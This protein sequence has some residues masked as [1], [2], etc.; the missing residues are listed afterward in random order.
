MTN[1]QIMKSVT[2]IVTDYLRLDEGE[3][4]P[5]SHIMSDMGADSLALI[6]LGFK[7]SETFGIGM[8]TPDE[9]M[10]IIKNLTNHISQEM[11]N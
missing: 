4:K 3:L 2:E 7:F 9:D 1:E 6:E 8:I 11:A 5:E 10:L